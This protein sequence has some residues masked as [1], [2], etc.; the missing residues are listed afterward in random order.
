MMSLRHHHAIL[1]IVPSNSILPFNCR[2][3]EN[4]M[5]ENKALGSLQA[6][7]EEL[8][9]HQLLLQGRVVVALQAVL[10]GDV[11]GA[12]DI[13]GPADEVLVQNLLELN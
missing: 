9:L 1:F 3:L 13:R 8:L 10:E 6:A 12:L 2:G 5:E 11:L 7:A 4:A